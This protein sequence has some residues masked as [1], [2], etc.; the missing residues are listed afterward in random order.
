[1]GYPEA[2]YVIGELEQRLASMAQKVNELNTVIGQVEGNIDKQLDTIRSGKHNYSVETDRTVQKI[3]TYEKYTSKT[4]I[5]IGEFVKNNNAKVKFRFSFHSY[6]KDNR[7]TV[8]V[9]RKDN[10]TSV[11]SKY[12]T[13]SAYVTDESN[14]IDSLELGVTYEIRLK[15]VSSA[16]CNKF[17]MIDVDGPEFDFTKEFIASEVSMKATSETFDG[18]AKLLATFV[19]E[20]D[21]TFN[22]RCSLK[23][24]TSS[25]AMR[26][27]IFED[28]D[29]QKLTNTEVVYLSTTTTTYKEFFATIALRK[30]HVY[31]IY[32][33]SPR[34]GSST[35]YTAYCNSLSLVSSL[36]E[37]T[38]TKTVKSVRRGIV[39]CPE[40]GDIVI[41]I[42]P[43]IDPSKT[44]VNIRSPFDGG[45]FIDAENAIR[46]K[47]SVVKGL[48]FDSLT[49]SPT[50]IVGSGGA[51]RTYEYGEVAY[52]LI[53]F[54]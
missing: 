48:T 14:I 43:F 42:Y 49:L 37:Y 46:N 21:G 20:Y 29:S 52:E 3:V 41:P 28:Y 1:M 31:S 10:N 2:E 39:Q 38:G 16:Y 19:P 11:Y 44:V 27:V 23:S 4:E 30:G 13:S 35:A 18:Y 25:Y 53:E 5:T 12:T 54:Y 6:G 22:L 33:Y 7:A 34:Y 40:E 9:Y 8:S 50:Y 47:V 51:S 15:G 32:M 26:L 24:S 45:A 17:D 36:E